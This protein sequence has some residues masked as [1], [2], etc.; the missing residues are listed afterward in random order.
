M[1]KAP[2][3]VEAPKATTTEAPVEAP[4]EPVKEESP[5]ETIAKLRAELAEKDTKL[6]E[7]EAKVAELSTEYAEVLPQKDEE[8]G[9]WLKPGEKVT[10]TASG[11]Y[12]IHRDGP[13]K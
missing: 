5:E 8:T 12:Q 3:K 9:V 1:A 7:S 4:K 13:K 10:V 2:S 6:Q 11:N